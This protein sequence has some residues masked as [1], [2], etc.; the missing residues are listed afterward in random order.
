MDSIEKA[1]KDG[2]ELGMTLG[3]LQGAVDLLVRQADNHSKQI[4]ELLNAEPSE[5]D[6]G[7][8][9]QCEIDRYYSDVI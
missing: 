6:R 7:H 1:W 9:Q 3:K 2:F 5:K 4:E 8:F